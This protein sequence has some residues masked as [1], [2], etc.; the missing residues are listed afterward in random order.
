MH[1]QNKISTQGQNY[2]SCACQSENHRISQNMNLEEQFWL[3]MGND[4]VGLGNSPYQWAVPGKCTIG[5]WLQFLSWGDLPE[6]GRYS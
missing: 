6:E 5:F 2:I 4:I 3:E 1:V